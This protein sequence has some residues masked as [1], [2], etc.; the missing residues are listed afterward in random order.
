MAFPLGRKLYY[1]QVLA[2]LTEKC[3]NFSA[4]SGMWD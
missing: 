4:F 2:K 3:V 1:P